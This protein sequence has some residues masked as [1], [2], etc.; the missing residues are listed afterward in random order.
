[1][2]S[3][4][5]PLYILYG[6]EISYFVGKVRAYMNYK[7]LN[8]T[9]R[10]PT[11]FDFKRFGKKLHAGVIPVVQLGNGDLIDD[12]SLIIESLEQI[13]PDRSIQ[14]NTAIQT[15]A[16][17][18]LEAWL[19]E[20]GHLIAIHTRWSHDENYPLF[21]D[22]MGKSMFP[23]LPKFIRNK[24]VDRTAVS[25]MKMN[26]IR[27]GIVQ[28]QISLLDKWID[29]ILNLLEQHFTHHEYLLGNR[30]SIADYALIGACY[31]HLYTDPWPRRELI[32][33]RQNLKRYIE[34]VH[35]GTPAT[36]DWLPD[37]ALPETLQPIFQMLFDE[38]LPLVQTSVTATQQYI[39]KKHKKQG[40]I[41]ARF[42][43]KIKFP[44]L[45]KPYSKVAF[46][47]TLWML[48]RI[49]S[50]CLKLDEQERI[51]VSSW[52]RI[53]SEIDFFNLDLGPKVER[54]GL[55]VRLR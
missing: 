51:K 3:E 11:I 10:A 20:V 13:H 35:S 23:W 18:M 28:E 46:S 34:R 39:E 54:Y 38:F 55:Q 41:I 21:R 27:F 19:D 33:P 24:L 14:P 8:Y 30:P 17:M 50:E 44:M 43:G 9:E 6:V 5:S 1:M 31:G 26:K 16:A 22:T 49:Q 12:T 36:G 42:P 4:P 37:E 48:Q 52:M 32:E 47:Y 29:K 45:G 2:S 53:Y 7:R 25:F 40:D 15:I